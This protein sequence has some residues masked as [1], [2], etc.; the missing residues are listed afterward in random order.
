M[1]P[2]KVAEGPPAVI[3]EE[4][5]RALFRA[6]NGPTFDDKRD[7]AILSVLMTGVPPDGAGEPPAR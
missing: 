2:P 6:T 5:L 1:K 3:P 4:T 7:R